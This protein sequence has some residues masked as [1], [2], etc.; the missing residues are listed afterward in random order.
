M[1]LHDRSF[2]HARELQVVRQAVEQA[3]EGHGG[4]LVVSAGAGV[5][6]TRMLNEAIVEAQARGFTVFNAAGSIPERGDDFEV[7]RHLF[8]PT[9]AGARE[10]E[11]DDLAATAHQIT[12]DPSEQR[13]LL[14]ALRR[15]ATEAPVLIAVDD[16]QWVDRSSLQWLNLASWWARQMPVALVVTVCEGEPC[17]D[18]VLVEE[19]RASGLQEVRPGPLTISSAVSIIEDVLGVIPEPSF[20]AACLDDT[21]GN[22]LLLTTLARSLGEH[23]VAPVAAEIADVTNIDL[24]ALVPI[25]RTRLRRISAHAF[26][27]A[28]AVA[29]LGGS[30]TVDRVSG[31]LGVEAGVVAETTTTLERFGLLRIAG[32]TLGFVQPVLQR[33][34]ERQL[35]YAALRTMHAQAARLLQ[36][37]NLPPAEVAEHLLAG[38]PI[39][40]PWAHAALRAAAA[41]ALESGAPERAVAYLR[42]ALAESVSLDDRADVTFALA[43][44]E[45]R[46]DIV[47]A[48]E[49]FSSVASNQ[50]PD[51]TRILAAEQLVE[52]LALT[53]SV[54]SPEHLGSVGMSSVS[55]ASTSAESS[56][57][58]GRS[59]IFDISMAELRLEDSD[60]ARSALA[61]IAQLR[62][63][64]G[65]PDD[66]ATPEDVLL[67][68]L[69]CQI[70]AW[71]GRARADTVKCAE[72][73]FGAPF[74]SP[75]EIRARLR[76]ALV[77]AESGHLD[78]AHQHCSVTIAK[79]EHWRHKPGLAAAYSVRSVVNRH[80][81]WLM[82]AVTDAREG[83]A[84]LRACRADPKAAAVLL[85]QARLVEAL[86][87]LGLHDEAAEMLAAPELRGDLPSTLGG[88]AL[89]FA[90]GRATAATGRPANGA[91]DLLQV[92]E[93]LNA[94]QIHNPA[95]LPW[96]S[97]AAEAVSLT[98]EPERAQRLAGAEVELAQT[99]GAAG[100]LGRALRIQGVV[101]PGPAKTAL[102]KR[103]TQVLEGSLWEVETALSLLAYGTELR[104]T[105]RNDEARPVLKNAL[106]L[107]RHSQS[108]S[109]IALARF[110]HSAAG[111]REQHKPRSA[112]SDLSPAEYR[113]ATL[114][115]ANKKNREIA[116]ALYVGQRAVEI[117]LTNCYRKLAISGREGLAA[118]LHERSVLIDA[119][120]ATTAGRS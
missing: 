68:S 38:E 40:E 83:L 43:R 50:G 65:A 57:A 85:L 111:G 5:G 117:H 90:R 98:G 61:R 26:A 72:S 8:G 67:T 101:T 74:T 76:A 54:G 34:L 103:S 27:V 15:A 115:A 81:G 12:D 20:V 88:V 87:D 60:T 93:R 31:M 44:A 33:L 45:S 42:R 58:P 1:P 14:D 4:L 53:G 109:L 84:L 75:S 36:E 48:V 13:N 25:L 35:S 100:P 2:A 110:Q 49:H 113:V 119:D 30:A 116:A 52:L 77:L 11:H 51:G 18:E 47:A 91:R 46:T 22:P 3:G 55:D 106:E 70:E 71:S 32:P 37:Y 21:Q 64:H 69:S 9:P 62:T 118:A 28:Q 104:Q 29:V 86:T 16:C 56:P 99:W 94:W 120:E 102:L 41:E 112:V 96:R 39:T 107:A 97:V 23:G 114:A 59:P 80:R 95:L 108:E 66:P 79:A 82:A 73:V 7:I 78:L 6:K 92:G 17:V 19:L 24:P 89:L 105:G 63:A 10:S